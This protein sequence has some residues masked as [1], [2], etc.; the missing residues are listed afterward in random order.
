[1][2]NEGVVAARHRGRKVWQVWRRGVKSLGFGGTVLLCKLVM[3]DV[4]SLHRL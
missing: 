2:E 4:R 1:M 3:W